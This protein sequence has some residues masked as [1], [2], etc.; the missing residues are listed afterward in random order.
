MV[1]GGP[2]VINETANNFERLIWPDSKDYAKKYEQLMAKIK[3]AF[4]HDY[5]SR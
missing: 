5:Y 1:T 4:W 3:E 2:K